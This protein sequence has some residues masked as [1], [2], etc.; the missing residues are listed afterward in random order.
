MRFI[1]IVKAN[2]QSEAGILPSAALLAE[3]GAFNEELARAGMLLAGDGLQPSAKGARIRFSGSQRTVVKGPF[4]ETNDL[5]AGFWLIQAQSQEDVI[6]WMKR[7]PFHEGEI[8]IRRLYEAED[9]APSDPA[10]VLR[11]KEAE[12]RAFVGS[13][14]DG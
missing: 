2:E 1:V 12:L 7:S 8:E 9:F 10:D 13:G 5:V 14:S 6:A 4:P 3:M 11:K